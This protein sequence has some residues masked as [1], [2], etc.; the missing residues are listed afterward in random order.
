MKKPSRPHRAGKRNPEDRGWTS[1]G[2]LY[3]GP[4]A[5]LFPAQSHT[6]PGRVS[7]SLRPLEGFP[8]DSRHQWAKYGCVISSGDRMAFPELRVR[9]VGEELI[10]ES[11]RQT[12]QKICRASGVV[13]RHERAA[14][15]DPPK[16]LLELGSNPAA[17]LGLCGPYGDPP[18]GVSWE[19][20]PPHEPDRRS[21]SVAEK[22]G[23]SRAARKGRS[24]KKRGK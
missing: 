2:K 21:R 11:R 24:G 8:F 6:A 5:D 20:S 10:L 19:T 18:D 23:G 22:G 3:A 13:G 12:R 7:L 14:S 4:L 17:S 16:P 15:S 1:I 9:K